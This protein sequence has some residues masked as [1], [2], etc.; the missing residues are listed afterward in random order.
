[1]FVYKRKKYF[2]SV[3]LETIYNKNVQKL[4]LDNQHQ[5][6]RLLKSTLT[7]INLKPFLFLRKITEFLEDAFEKLSQDTTMVVYDTLRKLIKILMFWIQAETGEKA[8]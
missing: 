1:M 2:L 7:N 8:N 5:S 4:L 3:V 6:I